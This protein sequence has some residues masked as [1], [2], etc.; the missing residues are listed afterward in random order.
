MFNRTPGEPRQ[1]A[2]R[3]KRPIYWSALGLVLA[4]AAICALAIWR[5]E[6][7]QALAVI[8]PIVLMWGVMARG[9]LGG[10]EP[11]STEGG[12]PAQPSTEATNA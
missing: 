7:V 2:V 5:W 1:R 10:E 11:T 6:P 9:F 3:P 8:N 4:S 12:G